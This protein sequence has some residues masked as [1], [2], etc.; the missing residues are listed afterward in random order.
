MLRDSLFNQDF[1]EKGSFTFDKQVT[2]VFDDMINRSV[3]LYQSIQ[4]MVASLSGRFFLPNTYIYDLGSSTGTT[5]QHLLQLDSLK[6]A[7]IKAIDSSD[8]MLETAKER[9]SQFSNQIEFIH[10]N[11]EQNLEIKNA[12]VVILNLVL[13]FIAPEYRQSLLKDIYEGLHKGGVLILVEKIRFNS[14][15]IQ[16]LYKELYYDFKS[17]QGYSE[18]EI[19]QKETALEGVLRPDTMELQIERLKKSGFTDVQTFFQCYNFTGIVAIK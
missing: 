11:L 14:S 19:K 3:P 9:L 2:A 18:K 6:A 7:Q 17:K 10:Q 8:S 5:I 1:I 15:V 4:D 16:D 12:S 13:Q